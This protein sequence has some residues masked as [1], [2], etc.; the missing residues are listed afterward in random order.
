MPSLVNS[1]FAAVS[2]GKD[3]FLFYQDST[4]I[5]SVYT[6]QGSAW[7]A[8]AA[9][10]AEDASYS[11]SAITAYYVEKDVNL[12]DKPTIHVL[13]INQSNQLVEKARELP[14]GSWQNI[15]L[16][17][18]VKKGPVQNSRLTSGSYNHGSGWNPLGSQWVYF[19][20]PSNGSQVITEIRR[21]PKDPW[22]SETV[23][24]QKFGEALPGASLAVTIV[25]GA[26]QLFFQDHDQNIILYENL[27]SEWVDKKV[28]IENKT[29]QAT[30]PLAAARE[31]HSSK[32]HV[33]F[34]NKDKQISHYY[35]G[36]EEQIGE[37]YPGT[38]LGAVYHENTL[39]VFYKT[40]HPA[41]QIHTLVY[42]D[43]KWSPGV[44]VLDA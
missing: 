19:V 3:V 36:K 29:V 1:D 6:E 8:I 42:K 35:N 4:K 27:G 24:P 44:K 14:S 9:P 11:G 40:I 34:A 10:I 12:N 16:A 37:Y 23:L 2:A 41:G 7:S 39:T 43:G 20:S 5:L 22:Y 25:Q 38:K 28:Y 30:S 15:A 13:Y 17:D 21:A 26:I 31:N 32:S 18:P 33:F